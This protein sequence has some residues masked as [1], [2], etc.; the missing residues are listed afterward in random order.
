MRK[1]QFDDRV[2]IVTGAGSGLGRAHTLA[3]A[4]RGARVVV[5]DLGPAADDVTR[6]VRLRGGRAIAHRGDVATTTGAAGL[7]EFAVAEFGQLDSVVNNAG[8]VRRG[9]FADLAAA[10]LERVVDVNLIAV[11]R[12]CRAAWPHLQRS[13]APRIVNTTSMAGYLGVVGNADYAAAKAGVVGLTKA[14]ALEG[15][16]TG[17]RVNALAPGAA[18]P[19]TATHFGPLM[20]RA[21]DP[22]KVSAAVVLLA[23]PACP[24]T[25]QILH[26]SGGRVALVHTVQSTGIY[27]DDPSPEDIL[28]RWDEVSD[29]SVLQWPAS[30]VEELELLARQLPVQVRSELGS[31][32]RP[33]HHAA[34]AS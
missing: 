15:A 31:H 3:L 23:H 18:T 13:P 1:M 5:N 28:A 14:L 25:G 11:A 17:I 10:D 30:V 21:L 7:V 26:A 6:E 22:S 9:R 19:M 16:S 33:G 8:V 4:D 32:Y 34:N 27:A 12:V 20:T 29:R 2:V 24:V